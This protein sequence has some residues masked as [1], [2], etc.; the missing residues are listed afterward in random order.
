MTWKPISERHSD[1]SAKGKNVVFMFEDN[2]GRFIHAGYINSAGG[3][4]KSKH[5]HPIWR[6][7]PGRPIYYCVLPDEPKEQLDPQT[8]SEVENIVD[9]K[10][11][12]LGITVVQHVCEQISKGGLRL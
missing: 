11:K 1:E 8:K 3:L 12:Q 6:P 5:D 7:L 9:Q 4:V 2:H 10:I